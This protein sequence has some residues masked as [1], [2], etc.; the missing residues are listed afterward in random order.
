MYTGYFLFLSVQGHSEVIW[1]IS[2]YRQ[3]CISKTVGRRGKWS[4][5]YGLWDI[6]NTYIGTFDIV[7]GFKVILCHSEHLS[8]ND[9]YLKNGWILDRG[10]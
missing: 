1:C 6:S 4:E 10:Y 9:L 7:V 8:Q 3:R 2:D 5:M